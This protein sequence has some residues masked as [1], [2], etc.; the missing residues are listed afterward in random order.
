MVDDGTGD[1]EMVEW[2][3]GGMAAGG[4]TTGWMTTSGMVYGGL[5]GWV[6]GIV[7]WWDGGW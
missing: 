3:D 4:M 1:G 2:R 7:R 6:V 5:V